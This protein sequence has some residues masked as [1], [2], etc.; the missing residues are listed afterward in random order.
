MTENIAPQECLNIVLDFVQGSSG[1][2][3]L[4]TKANN[5]QILQKSDDKSLFISGDNI[6]K[7]ITRE[8]TDGCL[9]LQVNFNNGTKILITDE[10]VG[11]SPAIK[12]GLD[13]SKL[14]KVVTTPDLV[15]VVEAIENIIYGDEFDADEAELL[16]RLFYSVVEGAENIGFNLKNEKGW[17][18]RLFYTN[19]KATA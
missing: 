8:D 5:V 11:F 2:N 15:N 4:D 10:L 7:V 1:L 12:P 19:T 18:K 16:K 14:P 9:F 17:I 13:Y 6:Q 3:I